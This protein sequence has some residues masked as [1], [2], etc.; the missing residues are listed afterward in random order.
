[1]VYAVGARFLD[2]GVRSSGSWV[3]TTCVISFSSPRC[4]TWAGSRMRTR[5]TR[6]RGMFSSQPSGPPMGAQQDGAGLA[7]LVDVLATGMWLLFAILSLATAQFAVALARRLGV[8]AKA[9]AVAGLLA[10][11]MTLWP[12]FL[13]NYMA[14]GFENSI[15]AAILLAVAARYVIDAY[16]GPGAVMV[17][18]AATVVAAHTWQ[19]LLPALGAAVLVSSWR[20]VHPDRGR[21]S[22]GMGTVAALGLIAALAA[23]PAV[24]AVVRDIGLAHASD[25]GVD[26]P[27][28]VVLL[29]LCTVA[30]LLIAVTARDPGV[31][32]SAVIIVMPL[33]IAAGVALRLGMSMTHYYPNKLLRHTTAAGLAPLAVALVQVVTRVWA[34]P[35]A[36]GVVLRACANASLALAV[37]FAAMNPLSA[38][39]G[40]WST[41]DGPTV[42]SAVT[43]A[44][45]GR[46]Q[47]VWLGAKGDNTIGRILL[48][49]Y[50]AGETWSARRNRRSMSRLNA[51]FCARPPSPRFSVTAMKRKCEIDMPAHPTCRSFQRLPRARLTNPRF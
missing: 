32:A 33:L 15:L 31:S 34:K 51:L 19:L 40:A 10:G 42:L 30:V 9:A 8:R 20:M 21:A 23:L 35:G 11:A 14:F 28:P 13:S 29:V 44:G 50:R 12:P 39:R 1:M 41:V 43:S 27:L 47:V 2:P 25:A 18:A 6:A 36:G 48:D 7:S 5:P 3:A 24:V 17:C 22:S 38:F 16:S 37:C 4:G 46:A 49:Y 26:P 45:A